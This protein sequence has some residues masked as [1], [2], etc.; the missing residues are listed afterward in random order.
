MKLNYYNS[1]NEIALA[2]K[3]NLAK[4]LKIAIINE[5]YGILSSTTYLD[6]LKNKVVNNFL[7]YSPNR[8]NQSFTCRQKY[9]C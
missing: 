3:I 7:I 5:F 6:C 2:N 9:T 1:N 4:F 8:M